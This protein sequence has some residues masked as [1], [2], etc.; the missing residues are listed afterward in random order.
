MALLLSLHPAVRAGQDPGGAPALVGA[1]GVL[2]AAPDPGI[3]AAL[4]RLAQGPA[5]EAELA[6]AVRAAGGPETLPLFFHHL[7]AWTARGWL[8]YTVRDGARTL[9]TARRVSPHLEPAPAPAAPGRPLRLS[10][11]ALLRV[12]DGRVCL[13]SP[14]SP[15]RVWLEA[16]AAAAVLALARPATPGQVARTAGIGAGAAAALLGLLRGAWLAVE[17]DDGAPSPEDADPALAH[18]EFHDLLFH[19]RSRM[20]RHVGGFGGTWRMEGRFPPLP[21]LRPPPAGPAV[22]LPRPDLERLLGDDV[23]FTRVLEERRS[24]RDEGER[25]VTLAELGELLFRAARVRRVIPTPRGELSSRP[26]PGGG[27]CHEL[28]L[29]LAVGACQGLEPGLYH[30]GPLEHVLTRVEAADPAAVGALLRD[31]RIVAH[32]AAPAQVLVVL[33]ARFARVAW[34]YESM[35]YALVLK[36]AGVLIQTLY[37]VATAMGLAPCALGGGDAD[38]FA[39]AAGT[40]YYAEGSVAELRLGG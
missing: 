16:E 40:D 17:A 13:E 33:A 18:W 4:A 1:G 10:R 29:Y 38:L 35:A 31:S 8:E 20:G 26:Y 6:G 23:P 34:K 12:D 19:A 11:F 9:A 7:R 22:P 5:S 21:A 30:Y 3:A 32:G 15:L 37:L 25:V 27:A 28:E 39:R 36:D 24:V 2:A 14:R